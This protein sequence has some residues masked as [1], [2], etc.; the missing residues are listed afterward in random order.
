MFIACLQDK[1]FKKSEL[2]ITPEFTSVKGSLSTET[3]LE[4]AGFITGIIGKLNFLANSQSLLSWAGT[5]IIAP[6]P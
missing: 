1:L 4:F 2:I 3:E 6:V 5:A